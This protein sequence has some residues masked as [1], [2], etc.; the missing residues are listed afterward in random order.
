MTFD[1][2]IGA[3][4]FGN[5]RS[6]RVPDPSGPA[7]LLTPLLAADTMKV[8]Y[9][10]PAF[11]TLFPIHARMNEIGQARR[12]GDADE[13]MLDE[14]RELRRGLASL[15]LKLTA[16]AFARGVETRDPFR[17]RLTAF[18]ADH[19]TVVARTSSTRTGV[20]MFVEETIRP[21][22]SGNFADMLKAAV[23]HPMLLIYLDQNLSV[24]PNSDFGKRRE[25]RGL[26]E[27]LAREVME[28]HTLGV[29][30]DYRQEDVRQLAKLFAGMGASRTNGFIYRKNR[31]EPN[32]KTVLGQTYGR[33]AGKL[34]D[35]DQVLDDIAVHPDT[36]R[37]IATKLAVHFV[38]D[39]PD[40]DLIEALR[41]RFAETEGNLLAVYEVLISHRSSQAGPLQ[42]ARQPIDFMVAS[43]RA[44]GARGD[45]VVRLPD[46]T[47]AGRILRA[48]GNM[49]QPLHRPVGPDG[50]EED[51]T[52][53]ITPLGLA[54][55]INWAMRISS[56]KLV[57]MPDPRDFVQTALGHL[58][59]AELIF[60]AQAAETREEGVGLVL[61]S[62][63]F[64]RR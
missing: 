13:D 31:A 11:D 63:D 23:K 38:S 26:N 42:K 6:P 20:P 54:V 25:G 50:W 33:R 21:Y 18:W 39:T 8:R 62:P 28:L 34:E 40:P 17:E 16:T 12:T 10:V 19:F 61:A 24:G 36:A 48:L 43:L 37:H 58:A 3:I 64:Q 30:G 14:M 9:R 55:R 41:R 27:N 32:P 29:D 51:A 1:P 53:W 59:S 52:H 56:L 35:V 49:G 22:I 57:Q 2:V 45:D 44:L 46:K 60:A 7:D 15:N 4:R 5:G 47:V